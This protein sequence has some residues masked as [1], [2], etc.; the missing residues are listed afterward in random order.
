MRPVFYH[1]DEDWAYQEKT[2]Y[3][4]GRDML[5]APV[6]REG[7]RKRTVRLPDDQWIHLFSGKEILRFLNLVGRLG[8]TRCR[9]YEAGGQSYDKES[10]HGYLIIWKTNTSGRVYH[11]ISCRGGRE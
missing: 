8:K 7:A 1:Y 5:V 4:L 3:L 9:E 10:L 11:R 6:Y 2:E